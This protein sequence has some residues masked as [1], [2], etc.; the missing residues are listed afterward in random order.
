MAPQTAH[1]PDFALS[2]TSV[3]SVIPK[4][5]VV[6]LLHVPNDCP[7]CHVQRDL[8]MAGLNVRALLSALRDIFSVKLSG[9][10]S[11]FLALR[12]REVSL[13]GWAST[14]SYQADS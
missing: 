7:P 1:R 5:D 12:V 14:L 8:Y 13:S 4:A 9:I 3:H 11:R 2:S 6:M 10:T